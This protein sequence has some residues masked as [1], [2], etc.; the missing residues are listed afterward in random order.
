MRP[1]LQWGV[2]GRR[3][4]RREERGA[5]ALE[6]AL[7][8]PILVMLVFGVISFGYMLSFRQALSQAAAEGGRAAAVQPSGT[9]SATRITAARSAINDALGS[10]GVTCTSGGGLTHSGGSSGTCTITI[11]ACTS[12]P[13]GAQCA[14]VVLHYPYK[15]N[16]LIPGLG[17]NTILPSDLEYTTEVRVS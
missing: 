17:I 15:N 4:G 5:A 6:F 10:Y 12:G 3:T 16:S 14:K 8:L 13:T 9:A 1:A 2:R 7:I 11:G